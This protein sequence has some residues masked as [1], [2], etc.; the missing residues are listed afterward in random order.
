VL[1]QKAK[2]AIWEGDRNPHGLE[3]TS[4]GAERGNYSEAK[5]NREGLKGRA[6]VQNA[7][8]TQGAGQT[9]WSIAATPK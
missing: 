1:W 7:E 9:R 8:A 4:E 2:P 5:H 3:L 6:C